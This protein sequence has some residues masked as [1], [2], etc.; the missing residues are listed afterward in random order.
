MFKMHD[1]SPK[2]QNH[3]SKVYGN[4]MM[5]ALVCAGGM[6]INAHT[7]LS[8]FFASIAVMIG[9]GYLGYK[10]SSP[11]MPEQERMGYMWALAFCMGFLVG[12]AMH[13]II[14]FDPSIIMNAVFITGVMFASFTA[15]S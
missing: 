11:Y 7:I 6:W 9:I 15:V 14:E 2:T 8:G 1:I 5:C 4:V 10:V 12:P 13:Q 3:L